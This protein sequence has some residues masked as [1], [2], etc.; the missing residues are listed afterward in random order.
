MLEIPES[1][2]LAEQLN[3]TVA[4]KMIDHVLAN[5]SPHGFAFYFDDPSGYPALL[6]NRIIDNAC[7]LAGQV[8]LAAGE[9]RIL[10]SDGVN[11][12][13]FAAGEVLP[14]KHQLSIEFMDGSA[15][16]ATVQMYGGLYAFLA[17]QNDNPYYLAAR[18][19][20]SPLTERFN[21]AYFEQLWA[22]AKP[23]LSVKAFLATEQRIHGLGNGVLQ[24][25]LF[26]ARVHP[27]SK[28]AALSAAE[29]VGLFT[30][31]KKTLAQMAARGGRDTEKDLFGRAG[32]YATILSKKTLQTPC[33]VCGG[34]LLRQ[35]YLGGNIYFCPACQPIKD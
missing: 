19:K 6:N 31:I 25:I 1:A 27:K 4:G 22:G 3:E 29:E 35:S 32:D 28:L 7:A 33:P 13:F 21:E 15:L 18:E 34:I 14:T 20:P 26:N 5:S 24:D 17:G 11:L 12:R 30:S 23:T 10:F 16:I 9:A 2:V 8:E